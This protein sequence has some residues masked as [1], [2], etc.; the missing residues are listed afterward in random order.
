MSTSAQA[1]VCERFKDQ[2]ITDKI[3]EE[4]ARLFC[5]N[6]GV[7]GPLAEEMLGAFAKK[8]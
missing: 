4:A 3:L 1:P 2:N 5:E 8:G 7:W 6:Y